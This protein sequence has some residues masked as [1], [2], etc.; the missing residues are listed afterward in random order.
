M[1]HVGDRM[2]ILAG[3]IEIV[4]KNQKKKLG[5]TGIRGRFEIIQTT[6]PLKLEN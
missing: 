5:E 4:C 3:T 6:A 1:E 2:P